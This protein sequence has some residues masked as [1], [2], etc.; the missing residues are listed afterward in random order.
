MAQAEASD[1]PTWNQSNPLNG[2][3]M[4]GHRAIPHHVRGMRRAGSAE[5]LVHAEQSRA[6]FSRA[7]AQLL[8]QGQGL[9][10][11]IHRRD[12]VECAMRAVSGENS[13]QIARAPSADQLP[14]D[15]AEKILRVPDQPIAV[16]PFEPQENAIDPVGKKLSPC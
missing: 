1:A 7:L 14:L 6:G 2:R 3:Q 9:K 13:G 10:R 8:R 16:Q 12:L 11:R 5:L 15:E 4:T